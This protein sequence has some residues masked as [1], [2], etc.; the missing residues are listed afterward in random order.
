MTVF[1]RVQW[2]WTWTRNLSLLSAGFDA[3]FCYH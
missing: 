2:W 3:S 1:I